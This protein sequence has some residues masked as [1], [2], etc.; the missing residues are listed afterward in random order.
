MLEIV[1]GSAIPASGE[2]PLGLL[3]SKQQCGEPRVTSACI[4]LH[5]NIQPVQPNRQF[6]WEEFCH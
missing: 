2:L 5:E 4:T 6:A 3:L 1:Q